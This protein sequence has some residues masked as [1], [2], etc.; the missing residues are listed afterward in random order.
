MSQSLS[1]KI[2][3]NTSVTLYIM[4]LVLSF[5][6]FSTVAAKNLSA[7]DSLNENN[8][9]GISL[10][11]DS[12]FSFHS[13]KGFIPSLL[14]DF[15]AQAKAPFK[16]KK[17]QAWMFAGGLAITTTLIFA[18]EKIDGFFKPLKT[19][20]PWIDYS[21]THITEFG[22][23]YAIAFIGAFGCSGILLKDRKAYQTTLL[24]AQAVITSGIWVRIGKILAARERPSATYEDF[25]HDKWW[26]PFQQFNTT[27]SKD[28]GVTSFDAFPSG[29]TATAFSIASVFAH[30]Y[31]D[32]KFVP[33][34]AYTLAS[35]VGVSRMTEHTHWASDV[36]AG[37]CIGYLCGRQ[38]VKHAHEIETSNSHSSH[39][40]IKSQYFLS[41]SENQPMLNCFFLF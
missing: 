12:V 14:Y 20:Q 6:S 10:C 29:H 13:Q 23:N 35:I 5:H 15:V 1:V 24:A 22:G 2:N 3:S 33:V 27:V 25:Q 11:R 26:G 41:I 28:R 19:K 32:K 37:A 30:Q 38:V 21:S 34:F 40:K 7:C 18:D 4:F 39:L 36:F 31:P 17:K 8:R 16:M 9:K